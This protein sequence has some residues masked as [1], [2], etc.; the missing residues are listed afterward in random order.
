MSQE[1]IKSEAL[2]N[3]LLMKSDGSILIKMVDLFGS[4]LKTMISMK[5]L[6][7]KRILSMLK[8]P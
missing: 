3:L 7:A 6:L 1:E 5:I 2:P 4:D 8:D